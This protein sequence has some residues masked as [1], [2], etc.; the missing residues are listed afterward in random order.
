MAAV[1]SFRI[2]R[3]KWARGGEGGQSALLNEDGNKCC[4]GFYALACGAKPNQIAGHGCPE[5]A[6][7]VKAGRWLLEDGKD[8]PDCY[9]LVNVNDNVNLTDANREEEIKRIFKKHRVEVKFFGGG[10]K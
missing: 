5:D 6:W 9:E 7:P 2:N 3:A 1:K 10:S 4:L 8:S